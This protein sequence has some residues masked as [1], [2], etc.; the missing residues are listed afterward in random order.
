MIEKKLLCQANSELFPPSM[1]EYADEQMQV[2]MGIKNDHFPSDSDLEKWTKI[3]SWDSET[4]RYEKK[5]LV[6]WTNGRKN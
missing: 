1:V 4:L 5:T 2:Y 3:E 6:R